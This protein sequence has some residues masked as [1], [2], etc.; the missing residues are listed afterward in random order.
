MIFIFYNGLMIFLVVFIADDFRRLSSRIKVIFRC[1][2]APLG[3]L[4]NPASYLNGILKWVFILLFLSMY[5]IL[6]FRTDNF[7]ARTP[8]FTF[9]SPW[10][11]SGTVQYVWSI[12]DGQLNENYIKDI[13]EVLFSANSCQGNYLGRK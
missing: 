5:M 8:N 1:D 6:Y 13:E 3:S 9:V 4:K 7:Q 2:I 12:S 10:F 11:V